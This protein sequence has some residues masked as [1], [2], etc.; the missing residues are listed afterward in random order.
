MVDCDS[1]PTVAEGLIAMPTM[2][3][4]ILQIL[5]P[6]A[7][8][9]STPVW[10]RVCVLVTGTILTPGRRT[11]ANALR[12]MGLDQVTGFGNY[13]RV[14]NR[15]RW[16]AHEAARVLLG[17]LIRSFCPTGAVVTGI[18]E[19]IE[20]RRGPK[21]AAKGIYRDPVR[22][23]RGHFVKA[24]G[25]RWVSMML[26]VPVPWSPRVWALPFL[27]V[28][29]PSPRYHRQRG[30][31]HKTLAD[32]ARQM[33]LQLRR[34]LPDRTLV[35]V[36]DNTYAVIE[37]LARC[38]QVAVIFVVR[39]RL[40]AALYAPAPKREPGAKGRPRVKGERLRSLCQ[41]LDDPDTRWRRAHIPNWYGQGACDVEIT[42]QTAVWYH[43]GKPVVPIRWVLVRDPE[44]RFE[45]RALACTDP[46][47]DAE[48]I[49]SWFLRRWQM[50]TTFQEARAHLGVETQRQ[51]SDLA[52]ARATPALLGLFS[53][54]T[55]LAHRHA[56]NG[57]LEVRQAIW[58]VKTAP[59][60]S[61]AL[62]SVRREIWRESLFSMSPPD[63]DIE[64]SRA[65][66]MQPIWQCLCHAA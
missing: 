60:F 34:W 21:I 2:P 1:C 48:Q 5:S 32:W 28:L 50:E 31:R 41:I 9:F 10:A 7:M 45:S 25:L 8:L 42:S 4:C 51:W 65:A 66:W 46:A 20:R 6:F 26:L 14:L 37:L 58:Y 24:S 39:F 27:T 19:T 15:A 59:T 62:A 36:G 55:L 54:V 49:L 29:A 38:R 44:G 53:I 23:S 22:S 43:P 61:D 17:L 35:V 57:E 40:D 12:A 30:T 33:V 63:S 64:K 56:S 47:E 11:V 16:S 52:I 18:D 13:H 3:G